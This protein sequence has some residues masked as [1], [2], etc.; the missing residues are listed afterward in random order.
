MAS[1][2]VLLETFIR[3]GAAVLGFFPCATAPFLLV[4]VGVHSVCARAAYGGYRGRIWNPLLRGID[5]NIRQHNQK[6]LQITGRII[7]ICACFKPLKCA[8]L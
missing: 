7:H 2:L 3:K 1:V 8:I 6:M 5:L 4:S